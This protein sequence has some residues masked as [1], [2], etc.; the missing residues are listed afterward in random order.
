MVWSYSLKLC[1]APIFFAPP[2][3]VNGFKLSDTLLGYY[4]VVVSYAA[5]CGI[6]CL[7]K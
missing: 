6:V 7:Y 1:D 4:M 5:P 3:A 2:R